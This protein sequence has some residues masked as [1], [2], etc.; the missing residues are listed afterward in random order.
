MS[1]VFLISDTH[2]GHTNIIKYCDRPFASAD[3]MDEALVENWNATVGPYDKVYHL[4]DVA[5]SH[6]KL[7]ILERLNG[8]KILIKG[9][10]D[11]FALKYYTPYFKDIR[12]THELGGLILSHI[13]LHESESRRFSGNVH[14]HLHE[15]TLKQ[16]WYRNVSVEQINYTPISLDQ[17]LQDYRDLG[18]LRS[19]SA[20]N[21][22]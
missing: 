1:N 9:N 15:K 19:G 10:H 6:K 12:A 5:M 21:S 20:K 18:F 16:L 17:V 2:F 3:D 13:P 7:P 14:G 11:I 8:T 4:G 22:I